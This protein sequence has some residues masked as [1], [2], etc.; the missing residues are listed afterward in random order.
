MKISE[1]SSF[2]Q[3]LV[4]L[5]LLAPTVMRYKGHLV[6]DELIGYLMLQKKRLSTHFTKDIKCLYTHKNFSIVSFQTLPDK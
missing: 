2:C 4:L 6:I 1:P 5:V 3:H